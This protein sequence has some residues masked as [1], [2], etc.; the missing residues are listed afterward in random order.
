[1][2]GNI[3][4]NNNLNGSSHSNKSLLKKAGQNEQNDYRSPFMYMHDDS[5]RTLFVTDLGGDQSMST[6]CNGISSHSRLDSK[7]S[8]RPSDGELSSTYTG[9]WCSSDDD[10]DSMSGSSFGN[11][12]SID[13]SHTS[14]LVEDSDDLDELEKG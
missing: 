12:Y 7:K 6:Q 13:V 10:D 2:I 8:R 5:T 11:D 4:R 3:Y 9:S 1:M 14:F